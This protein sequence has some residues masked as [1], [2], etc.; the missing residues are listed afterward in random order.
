MKKIYSLLL[1]TFGV[2]G[3]AQANPGDTTWVQAHNNIHLDQYAYNYDQSVSFPDGAVTYRKIIMVVTLGEYACPSGAQYCHQWDYDIENY[4]MTS[5]DTFEMARLITPFANSGWSRFPSTWTQPYA[6]DVTDFYPYLKNNATLRLYFSGYSGGFTADVKFAFIEG[7]PDRNVTGISK[8]Y[9]QSSDYGNASNPINNN[10]AVVDFTAPTGTA[11][12]E[13]RS[14]ITGHGSDATAQCCEFDQHSMTVKANNATIT[15]Q[16]IWRDNCGTND[17]Y[18]QGGTWTYERSNWCPGALV[19]P[20]HFNIPSITSGTTFN[21]NFVFASYTG[22]PGSNG[23]GSYKINASVVFHGAVNKSLDASLEEIINPTNHPDHFRSNPNSNKPTIVVHNSGSTAITSLLVKYNVADS[24]TSE[25]TWTGNIAS[26]SDATIVLPELSALTNLSKNSANGTYNFVAHIMQ[27]NGVTDED[28]TN[29]KLSTPFI[30]APNWPGDI[31]VNLR[32]GNMKTNGSTGTSGTY[33]GSWSITDMNNNVIA[34]QSTPQVLQTL[35]DT[36]ALPA[37]GYYKLTIK[38]TQ[39]YGLHWWP[40]DNSQYGIT[41]GALIVKKISGENIPMKGYTYAGSELKDFGEHDDFGC[42]Y[43][44]YFYVSTPG[45]TAIA[46]PTLSKFNLTVY[47]NPAKDAINIEVLGQLKEK[48]QI[49]L[50]NI[51]GQVV[52]KN[53]TKDLNIYISIE[54]IP[55]GIYLLSYTVGDVKKVEKIIVSK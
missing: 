7:T 8:L 10:L 36:V 50:T 48:A 14:I 4:I 42:E 5:T 46:N 38:S 41:P 29:D 11:S 2:F 54:N 25:F 6:F 43:T 51:I 45:T 47:P 22:N 26:L 27:V 24:A 15:T 55:N 31:V 30:V 9:S 52:Y 19:K 39:C 16:S 3:A 17:L 33:Q 21:A 40:L 13:I 20:Y 37:S 1:L 34:S 23:Y 49:Q 35:N 32:T 28:G 18:P 44:Q 12:A 53:E